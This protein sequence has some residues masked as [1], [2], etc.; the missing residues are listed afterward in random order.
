MDADVLVDALRGPA[1]RKR[2]EW[3]TLKATPME[4]VIDMDGRGPYSTVKVGTMVLKTKE[5]FNP[6]YITVSVSDDAEVFTEVAHKDYPVEGQFEPN[7]LKEYEVS[8]TETSARYLKIT[9]GCLDYVPQWH[10]YYGRNASL[11]VDEI[12]VN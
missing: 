8:F 10:H 11:F 12:M 2:H 3:L 6:T 7:G 9:V 5:V 4:V 1:V